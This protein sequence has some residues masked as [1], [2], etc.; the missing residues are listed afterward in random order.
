MEWGFCNFSFN[1]LSQGTADYLWHQILSLPKSFPWVK[2]LPSPTWTMVV[3]T[4]SCPQEAGN[5]HPKCEFR[6]FLKA[7]GHFSSTD[8][9]LVSFSGGL[10]KPK[11]C[12][13][14]IKYHCALI[15]TLPDQIL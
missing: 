8:F 1:M 7:C 2:G 9:W 13:E 6:V 4:Q 5:M 10:G 3:R 11:L 14:K 12:P 15:Q